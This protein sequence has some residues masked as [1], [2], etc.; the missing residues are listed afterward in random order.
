MVPEMTAISPPPLAT[1]VSA[2]TLLAGYLVLGAVALALSTV[3]EPRTAILLRAGIGALAAAGLLAGVRRS[4]R[5]GTN[6]W[7]CFAAGVALW[8][9]G[10]A[11]G[12]LAATRGVAVP[13]WADGMSLAGYLAFGI[14]FVAL[15]RIGSDPASRT[16]A[17]DAFVLGTAT[18][19]AL[20]VGFIAPLPTASMPID[21]WVIVLASPWQDGLLVAILAWIALSP[22]RRSAALRA[23][24]AGL[25]VTLA[26]NLVV[27]AAQRGELDWSNISDP[28]HALGYLLIGMAGLLATR[29]I[30]IEPIPADASTD[31]VGRSVLMGV[32]LLTGPLVAV[33]GDLT[34]TDGMVMI[35]TCSTLL[36][37]GVVARFVN[38]VHQ[39][40]RA[41]QAT[42]IS[43]RRFRMLADSAPVGIFELGRGFVVTYAN[44]EGRRL[45]GPT[46]T[47]GSVDSMLVN[48]DE[49]GH[50]ALRQ[51]FAELADGRAGAADVRLV[52]SDDEQWMTFQGVP[53]F[54]GGLSAPIAFASTLDI[55]NLKQAESALARQATHDPLTGLPNRRRLLESLIE[56]LAR[57]GQGHRTGTVALMFVD[58]DGFKL[59]NDV[60]G[61]DRGDVLLVNAAARLRNAVRAHDVVARFG[62][63][64]FVV[65]LQHVSDRGELHELAQRILDALTAP[66]H[67]GGEPA[68]VG[69]SIGIAT[70]TG[71]DDDPDALIRNADAA[72]YRAKERG[73]GRYEF[74]RPEASPD[75]H[76]ML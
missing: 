55:T 35:G 75:R 15:A 48:V 40:Q 56:A 61:H 19:L 4:T 38:L 33:T 43:E 50:D 59:V 3:A 70:A 42:A 23:I 72:M 2:R 34:T 41:H 12:G 10:S 5:I 18:V 11:V 14:G 30:R 36:A 28:L 1:R 45:L 53:V 16:A 31:H 9:G 25:A 7:L 8:A 60:L 39:N 27:L 51:A 17:L 6:P 49:T 32:A 74:F 57:L 67:V 54:G 44:A 71:P 64:E 52:G 22:G 62:G 63:D 24:G 66:I 58:L 29:E 73:R 13:S 69:A 20:W 68:Q 37:I 65:L 21:R 47:G 76:R 46:V 26:A